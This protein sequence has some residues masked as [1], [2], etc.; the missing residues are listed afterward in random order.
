M[1]KFIITE[2]EKKHIKSLYE[3]SNVSSP[4]PFDVNNANDI[5]GYL[6]N[7][8][9][10]LA[11]FI[12]KVNN[13]NTESFPNTPQVKTFYGQIQNKSNDEVAKQLTNLLVMM[14]R[15]FIP[16]NAVAN[17]QNLKPYNPEQFISSLNSIQPNKDFYSSVARKES[18]T[19]LQNAKTYNEIVNSIN[20]EVSKQY[21]E[22]VA[23]YVNKTYP[24]QAASYIESIN[25]TQQGEPISN[26]LY[27]AVLGSSR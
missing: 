10:F 9:L 7:V 12:F 5:R 14:D 19:L 22:R 16:A 1:R 18:N 4:T 20:I 3:Q 17:K 15:Q 24:Q 27:R 26:I 6:N 2:E 8:N 25:P 21:K 13:L 11:A 23:D